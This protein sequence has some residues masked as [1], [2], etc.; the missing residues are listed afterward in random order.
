MLIMISSSIDAR[1]GLQRMSGKRCQQ[2]IHVTLQSECHSPNNGNWTIKCHRRPRDS[3]C[4]GTQLG[5]STPDPSFNSRVYT[6]SRKEPQ[7]PGSQRRKRKGVS[8]G[9]DRATCA[10]KYSGAQQRT[11]LKKEGAKTMDNGDDIVTIKTVTA[12]N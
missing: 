11:G 6:A 10:S 12:V 7:V 2:W 3:L 4:R 9:A 5:Q 1:V 8:T